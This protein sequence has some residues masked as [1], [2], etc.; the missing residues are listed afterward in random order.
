MD[1]EDLCFIRGEFMVYSLYHF[2]VWV[3]CQCWIRLLLVRGDLGIL[4]FNILNLIIIS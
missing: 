4:L 3:V 1:N 2:L